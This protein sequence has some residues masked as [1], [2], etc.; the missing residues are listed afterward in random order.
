M[1]QH[2][3]H[4]G[5]ETQRIVSDYLQQFWPYAEPIGAGR[6]GADI[7][8]VPFDAE[9]KARRRLEITTTMAQLAD[10]ATDGVPQVAIIRPDGYGPARI[11][12]WPAIVTLAEYVRLFRGAHG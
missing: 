12:Q 11:E 9:I 2:R 3:K 6:P 8:G 7:T 4:R 5:Y 10:R 1:S